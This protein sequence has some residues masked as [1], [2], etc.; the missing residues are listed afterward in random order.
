[1]KVNDKQ[2]GGEHYRS[3]VQ[4]W[5]FVSLN[6]ISYVL[7]CATKYVSRWRKKHNYPELF[8][9]V[10]ACFGVKLPTPQEDLLK[11]VHYIEKAIELHKAGRL[12]APGSLLRLPVSVDDFAKANK[13][14]PQERE[15]IWILTCWD[16]P[17][18]L[19]TAI[20]HIEEMAKEGK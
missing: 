10:A 11:S 13:L 2:I 1:M 3:K 8:R 14:T 6:G 7:G 4:H 15:V 5:D 20:L 12:P 17:D 19:R 9:Q 18:Q 16:D